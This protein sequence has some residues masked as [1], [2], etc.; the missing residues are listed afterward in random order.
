MKSIGANGLAFLL[1]LAASGIVAAFLVNGS[2]RAEEGFKTVRGCPDSTNDGKKVDLEITGSCTVK[3]GEYIYHNVNIFQAEP[4]GPKPVLKFEDE[5]IDFYA[6]SILVENNS[7]LVAGEPGKPIGDSGK[8][9]LRIFLYGDEKDVVG[10]QCKTDERCGVDPTIWNSNTA[11]DADPVNPSSCKENVLPGDVKDCFYRYEWLPWDPAKNLQE[12]SYFGHKV[13]AVSYGGTLQLFGKKGASYSPDCE[14]DPACSGKS[15]VRLAESLKPGDKE[16][17]VVGEVDWEEDDHIVVTTTDYLPGHSEELVI[18]QPP[19]VDD[20]NKKTTIN[21]KRANATNTEG[22]RIRY[23]HNGETY[24]IPADAIANTGL[25][26]NKEAETRAA[27]ALLS[28]SIRIVSK[29]DQPKDDLEEKPGKFF[30]GHTIVRQGFEKFQIQGV[31]F[32]KMGQGGILGRYPIHFHLARQTPQP[33]KASDAPVTFVKD[34]TVNESMTRWITLHGTQG[35]TLARNVGYRSIGHGFYLEDGTETDN[36]LLS[37]IG[38]FARAAI[39]NKQN[40]REVPG[41]LAANGNNPK[42]DSFP[43]QSDYDFPSAF[44]ITNGWNDFQNNMAAGAGSCG[45][46][47]WLVP[48]ANSGPS[49]KM[50]WSG[51]AGEQKIITEDEARKSGNPNAYD[52]VG[53]PSR[54]ALTPLRNF[55]GNFCSTAMSAFQVNGNTTPCNGI[56]TNQPKDAFL[57]PIENKRVP[58]PPAIATPIIPAGSKSV[59]YFPN[60]SQGGGHFSTRCS[61]ADCITVTRCDDGHR[62]NCDVTVIDGFTTS[63]NWAAKNFSAIWLRP[64]W[65]LLTNSVI[66]DVQNAGVTFVTGGG[67]SKSDVITGYWGLARRNVFIGDTQYSGTNNPNPLASNAGPFNPLKAKIGNAVI[68]GLDCQKDGTQFSGNACLSRDEGIAMP[69]EAFSVNQRLFSVYDGPAYQDSNVYLSIQPTILSKPKGATQHWQ[70]NA[71]DC[72]P[73]KN[74]G[75]PCLGSGWMSARQFGIRADN[76]DPKDRKCSLPNAAIGWKQ[77]NAFYYAPAFHSRNLYF[78]KDVAIRHFVIEPLF[79]PGTLNINLETAKEE[80]CNWDPTMF[81][82]FTGIDRMTVLNDDDGSLTGLVAKVG[83]QTETQPTLSIN[84]DEFFKVPA[85]TP[86]CASDF[87]KDPQQEPATAN[88]SPYEYLTT[89]VFPSEDCADGRNCQAEPKPVGDQPI[90]N[91]EGKPAGCAPLVKHLPWSSSCSNENCYGAPLYRQLIISDEQKGDQQQVRMAGQNTYQRSSLTVSHGKYYLDTTKSEISQRIAPKEGPN[92]TFPWVDTGFNVFEEKKKYSIFF[93]YAKPTTKQ[94]YQIYVGKNDSY[95]AEEKIKLTRAKIPGGFR[96]S[97]SEDWP[98]KWDRSY[99]DGL[100]TVTVDMS[101]VALKNEFDLAENGL[102]EDLCQPKSMC[103]W[104]SPT[105]NDNDPKTC[106]FNTDKKS[107]PRFK[108]VDNTELDAICKWSVKEIDCPKNGCLGF[109]FTMADGFVA[110]DADHRPDPVFFSKD[111]DTYWK[112]V[113]FQNVGPEVSGDAC[114]CPQPPEPKF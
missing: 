70:D 12:K 94:T 6:E 49:T 76:R 69:L 67:Y 92:I 99:K 74:N 16:M 108:D 5:K 86:E 57:P 103:T 22:E 17:T 102:G 8:G 93:V 78:G 25:T 104:K 107:D 50:W 33:A 4:T 58:A 91:Q 31:E 43:F 52:R 41:I 83:D 35:V 77:S 95:K 28:R 63:F 24:K 89:V 44:W 10:I 37:N 84:L 45:A 14:Q 106:I 23:P 75:F 34:S 113:S 85:E 60:V 56:S 72:R 88:T 97:P 61:G 38:I 68:K 112:D 110:D 79:D 90:C 20:V 64:Q 98:D 7:S 82:G 100:L 114:H 21:F 80:Y 101:S 15:W 42:I 109:E 105:T 55:T 27:V 62:E 1:R 51:Y 46:C 87:G 54:A 13:L 53:T 29:E 71:K 66:T 40:K 48:A 36:R 26:V 11:G 2:I 32:R 30:G 3:V 59:G 18:T 39:D 65:A 47:Y 81:T 9:R 19:K 96:F 73:D 111:S